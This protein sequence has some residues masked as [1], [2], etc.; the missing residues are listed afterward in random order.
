MNTYWSLFPAQ[1]VQGYAGY[2]ISC[3]QHYVCCFFL[4]CSCGKKFLIIIF[5]LISRNQGNSLFSFWI[6]CCYGMLTEYIQSEKWD[7]LQTLIWFFFQSSGILHIHKE[8]I[9]QEYTSYTKTVA[10]GIIRF[11]FGGALTSLMITAHLPVVILVTCSAGTEYE[12]QSLFVSCPITGGLKKL[13][14][15]PIS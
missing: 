4:K 8:W 5:I 9:L 2:S 12:I 3:C 6:W 1:S 13:L 10:L 7:C 15:V 11:F 14:Q